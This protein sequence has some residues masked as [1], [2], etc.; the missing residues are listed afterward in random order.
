VLK[1]IKNESCLK[2][3]SPPAEIELVEFEGFVRK[4]SPTVLEKAKGLISENRIH[5][6]LSSSWPASPFEKW[7]NIYNPVNQENVELPR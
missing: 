2:E 6:I 1:D 3:K 4:L 7:R 5:P